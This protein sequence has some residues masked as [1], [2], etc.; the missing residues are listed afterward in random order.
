MSWPHTLQERPES[1][2][3]GAANERSTFRRALPWVA[4]VLFGLIVSLPALIHGLPDLAN[5]GNDHARFD[6]NFATQF[7]HGE[8]YP[9][10]L[11]NINGGLGGPTFFFYPPLQSFAASLFWPFVHLHD[12][13]GWLISGY[14]CVLA[15]VLA[16]ITAFI[17]LRSFSD[18]GSALFGAAVYM[19]APY[20]LAIDLYNRAAAAEYWIFVWLPLLMLAARAIV[21]GSRYS[22]SAFAVS[23]ALCVYSHATVAACSAALPLAYVLMF[24]DSRRRW[25]AMLVAGFGLA[26][27]IGLSA[28][29]LLPAVFDQSKTWVDLY[30]TGWGDY[31]NWWL[32]QIRDKITE[33]GTLGSGIPWYF[34]YKMRILVITMWTLIFSGT[35]YWL[36]R[37]YST[38]D[39]TRRIAAFYLGTTLLTFFLMLR[40]SDLVWRFVPILRLLQYP[41]RLSTFLA[42]ATAAL[43]CLVFNILPQKGARFGA[44]VIVLSILGWMAADGVSARQAY[45]VWRYV[46]PARAAQSAGVM[47]TQ[48]EE[49]S[50]WPKPARVTELE[51]VPVFEKFLTDHPPKQI[52]LTGSAFGGTA[53][54]ESW[55]PRKVLLKVNTSA[56]G[57]LILNHFYMEGWRARPEGVEENLPLTP[58]QPDGLIAVSLPAGAFNLVVD[59]P[60][61]R[62]E[63]A[64]SF[65]SLASLGILAALLLRSRFSSRPKAVIA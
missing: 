22:L 45:G 34:S 35:S 36:V 42:L 30:S 49:S 8:I 1:R 33:T 43:A 46:P 65:I 64:G 3:G 20:H 50:Y 15:T 38:S 18:T 59:L 4:L 47:R 25:R 63:I 21:S 60:A 27:G 29:F 56:P 41:H 23:Y 5:D 61:D 51:A 6:G 11:S 37:R 17:W 7:W 44:A 39:K 52:Y 54:V 57:Q 40:Q 28:I 62:S 10:W 14:A 32:F 26:L 48:Q 2:A 12:P 31:R 16:G 58:S 19:I 53:I 24:S 13:Y 9:R 55:K